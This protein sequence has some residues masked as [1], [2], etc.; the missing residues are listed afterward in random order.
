MLTETLLSVML[1]SLV[2][3]SPDPGGAHN[4]S[5]GLDDLADQVPPGDVT[6][7]GVVDY[8]D[9]IEHLFLWGPCED[10]FCPAD[11]DGDKVVDVLDFVELLMSLDR[12]PMMVDARTTQ[13]SL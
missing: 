2:T 4:G 6:L 9:V 11:L 1:A 10:V 5:D 13:R 7:D 8:D 3:M 12:P